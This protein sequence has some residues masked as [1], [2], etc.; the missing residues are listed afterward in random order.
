MTDF[1]K[2]FQSDDLTSHGDID[3]GREEVLVE[4]GTGT[5]DNGANGENG[6]NS[7]PF[8]EGAMEVIPGRVTYLQYLK[9]PV[10]ALLVGHGEDQALLTAHQAL[11][12][13]SPWFAEVC[14]K[15]SNEV[16]VRAPAPAMNPQANCYPRSAASTS[17][18]KT[19]TPWAASW[20]T[21]TR[22]IT[23]RA[24]WPGRGTWSATPRCPRSTRRATSC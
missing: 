23:S 10:I 7:L 21:Y 1:E 14:A 3:M 15:F 22:G 13:Q 16:P 9:S 8:V 5:V 12:T 4:I 24:G 17:S 20:S 18:T 19:S 6:E 11:L 2:L